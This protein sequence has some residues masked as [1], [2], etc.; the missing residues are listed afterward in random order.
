MLE[1]LHVL[2][3]ANVF[4]LIVVRDLTKMMVSKVWHKDSKVG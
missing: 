3:R 2:G 4:S 1:K